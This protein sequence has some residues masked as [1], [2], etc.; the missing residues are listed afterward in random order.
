MWRANFVQLRNGAA[1]GTALHY[2]CC[3]ISHKKDTQQ[4]RV[5]WVWRVLSKKAGNKLCIFVNC[6]GCCNI[7][8]TTTAQPRKRRQKERAKES[9]GHES[10]IKIIFQKRN[11]LN[12]WDPFQ[13]TLIQK[14]WLTEWLPNHILLIDY[15]TDYWLAATVHLGQKNNRTTRGKK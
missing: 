9:F 12:S 13:K 5:N 4:N 11:K 10:I 8:V 1:A 6:C 7:F 15:A 14:F 2:G 3:E